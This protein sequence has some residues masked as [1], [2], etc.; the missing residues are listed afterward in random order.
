[1][2]HPSETSNGSGQT[3]RRRW[4]QTHILYYNTFSNKSDKVLKLNPPKN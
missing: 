2:H 1:M 3:S 4:W